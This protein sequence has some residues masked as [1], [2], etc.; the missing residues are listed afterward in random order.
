MGFVLV[1]FRLF[2]VYLCSPMFCLFAFLCM[3]LLLHTQ[4]KKETPSALGCGSSVGLLHSTTQC[5]LSLY[6]FVSIISSEYL[7]HSCSDMKTLLRHSLPSTTALC[8]SCRHMASDTYHSYLKNVRIEQSDGLDDLPT[9]KEAQQMWLNTE[10]WSG[11]S[12][13]YLGR[14]MQYP[15]T[16]EHYVP[17]LNMRTPLLDKVLRYCYE[18]YGPCAEILEKLHADP[19]HPRFHERLAKVRAGR[20]AI[21]AVIDKE[22]A[23]LHPTVKTL[24]DA[25]LVRRYFFLE[26]WAKHVE[27]KRAQFFERMS[28]EHITFMLKAKGLSDENIMRLEKMQQVLLAD[29]AASIIP[30]GYHYSEDEVVMIRQKAQYYR[31]QKRFGMNFTSADTMPH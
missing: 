2:F 17:E 26:D 10:Q 11:Y 31:N 24:W 15:A 8:C 5:L 30:E 25:F 28:P 1:S 18:L 9:T 6:F 12:D 14:F 21:G 27:K 22:Y 20:D 3:A 19:L 7:S 16:A 23:S 4:Y 29:P 13:H